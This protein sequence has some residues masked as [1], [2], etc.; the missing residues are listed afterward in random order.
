MPIC[1]RCGVGFVDGELH[2][3]E[4]RRRTLGRAI[5]V[6]GAPILGGLCGIVVATLGFCVLTQSNL[7]GLMGMVVG[8]PLGAAAGGVISYRS[9]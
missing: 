1:P 7:C 3:C 2:R 5:L 4:G 6:F 8:F 9:R